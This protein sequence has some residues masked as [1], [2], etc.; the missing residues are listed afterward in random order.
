MKINFNWQNIMSQKE[1]NKSMYY[2]KENSEDK[3][4]ISAN[5]SKKVSG[6]YFYSRQEPVT[7]EISCGI[8]AKDYV[9]NE[10]NKMV[11]MSNSMS[12]EDFHK[13]KEEGYS[14]SS[15]DPEEIV[16][17]LDTIKT[18]LAKSGTHIAGYTDTVST[19][20]ISQITGN[21]GYAEAIVS[22]L[23]RANTPVTEE[24]IH[25]IDE[26]VDQALTL[27]KP[28]EGN[29]AYLVAKQMEPTI[30]N[31]YKA[32]H[33]SLSIGGDKPLTGYA[34]SEYSRYGI[35]KHLARRTS[36]TKEDLQ[37]MEVHVK[38]RIED[39]EV[40]VTEESIQNGKWLVEKGLPLTKENLEL[41]QQIQEIEFPLD[42][43]KIIRQSAFAIGEGKSPLQ[44]HL[45]KKP[46]SIYEKAV[47][48]KQR[49]ESLSFESAD[50][51][52]WEK[53]PLTLAHLEEYRS[54]DKIIPENIAARKTL[55]EVRLKM[56]VEANIRLLRSGYSIDTAP[57]EELIK[58]LDQAE[59]EWE[60]S[61]FGTKNA[62]Q[63]AVL[64]REAT[65]HIRE[66]PRL[67]LVTIGKFSSLQEATISEIVEEGRSIKQQFESV[68][69]SYEAIMTAPRPDMGDTIKKAFRNIDDILNDMGMEITEANQR[70]IRIMGYNQITI[71]EDNL[72]K[73]KEADQKVRTVIEKL[74]PAV[75]LEMVREG[76]NP[77]EM[78]MDEIQGYIASRENDFIDSTDKY[79]EFLYKLEKKH[80][81]TEE[82]RKSYIGIYRL[83]RQIEK[84]D[85]GV[86]GSLVASDSGINFSNLLSAVRS[87][88]ARGTDIRV[89][90]S[91]G[92]LEKVI[93]KGISISDQIKSMKEIEKDPY[94]NDLLEKEQL[95]E[96]REIIKNSVKEKEYLDIYHQPVTV[97]HL[98]SV[99][100]LTK[101]RG[102]TFR[103][104]AEL[105]E[106]ATEESM[107]ESILESA[108]EFLDKI[109]KKEERKLKYNKMIEKSKTVL[110]E[111]IEKRDF[112]H[113]NLK[114]LQSVYKQLSLAQ[115]LSEEENY[116]VPIRI[117]EEITSINL[118]V[119]H[120][121]RD[122]G[123][124]KITMD[125][126]EWGQVEARFVMT[127]DGLEGSVLTNY[128]DK[129]EA[130]QLRENELKEA[131]KEA[132]KETKIELK[133]LFFAENSKL[134]INL[135]EKQEGNREKDLSIL[136]KVAKNFVRY[137][138]QEEKRAVG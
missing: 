69:Q 122:Y 57:M 124:V 62:Q 18:E 30:S 38:E 82:E 88:K 121:S 32:G 132:L 29:I 102:E 129:K 12:P 81:I 74:K 45:N 86:I 90:D 40:K 22:E 80:Q 71:T 6:S 105:I 126:K 76:K 111:S 70:A 16:T 60:S 26:A 4:N 21:I 117:G 48:L 92:T 66:L 95:Q 31:L 110:E 25:Q 85:G 134:D 53:K 94:L 138:S 91:I 13:M 77:L 23:K 128:M 44:I 49:F 101:K 119:V 61:L 42:I 97:D 96:I 5:F 127:E 36:I 33:S 3:K 125:T 137:I 2:T 28:G 83:I 79:S 112:T 65:E 78:S 52:V 72:N 73:I 87:K 8:Q 113:L 107:E 99:A 103:K 1:M 108:K 106:N 58:L 130:L 27:K 131:I 135:P 109:D 116:E 41:L 93:E 51:A 34:S 17:I 84:S 7:E 114:E 68:K 55:E 115:R 10:R 19:E 123:N 35:D 75:V 118:K 43:T 64:F 120:S 14:I 50:Q 47:E 100:V 98:Q 39:L 46:E 11:V 89:D 24:N 20:V 37:K 59:G 67:P 54:T 133:S 15:M 56:T 63:K 136:Y 9:A 104:V